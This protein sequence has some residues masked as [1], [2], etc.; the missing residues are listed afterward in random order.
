MHLWPILGQLG[1]ILGDLGSILGASWEH[2]TAS[3]G[4]F[5]GLGNLLET[6]VKHLILISKTF[7]KTLRK[8]SFSMILISGGAENEDKICQDGAKLAPNEP[9]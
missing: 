7:Q 5:E 3:W 4:G 2:F 9:R 1:C 6:S 8:H